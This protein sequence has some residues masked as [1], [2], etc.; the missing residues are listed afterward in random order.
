MNV[1]WIKC[2]E[3]NWCPFLT[4]NL[5]HGHFVGL[6]GVY[7]IWHGG[8]N[9]STVYVGKGQIADRIRAHRNSDDILKFSYL[10]L[11]VTWAQVSPS[12]QGGVERFLADHLNPKVGRAHPQA[13]P[14]PVNFPW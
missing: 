14:I 2:Q 6:N 12:Q 3:S 11:F 1:N 5:D 9:P 4:L 13:T 10:G 7:V 8:M